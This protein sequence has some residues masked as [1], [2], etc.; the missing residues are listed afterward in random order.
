[1]WLEI[2]PP[3]VFR[4]FSSLEISR[5]VNKLVRCPEWNIVI[6]ETF[7][8]KDANFELSQRWSL[9]DAGRILYP[10]NRQT[11][12][13]TLFI[14]ESH[15][16]YSRKETSFLVLEYFW[17]DLWRSLSRIRFAYDHLSLTH[18]HFM[19]HHCNLQT[20]QRLLTQL[21]FFSCR[22]N[23]NRFH[24]TQ[25][26]LLIISRLFGRAKPARIAKFRR[27]L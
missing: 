5:R 22:N 25:F 14:R 9:K 27:H 17:K 8:S 3:F 26:L 20:L 6:Y 12:R 24:Y 21:F 4:T 19:K 13:Q 23:V 11:G 1:M 18:Q 16:D 7:E 15:R 2:S 10:A